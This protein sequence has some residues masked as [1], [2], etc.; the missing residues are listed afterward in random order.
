LYQSQLWIQA[1]FGSKPALGQSQ[2]WIL[3]SFG[4]KPT[5]DPSQLLIQATWIEANFGSTKTWFLG[6]DNT[7]ERKHTQKRKSRG[8]RILRGNVYY[9]LAFNLFIGS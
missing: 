3:A 9:F 5:F 1:S 4:S 7:E 6:V 8:Y 2:L